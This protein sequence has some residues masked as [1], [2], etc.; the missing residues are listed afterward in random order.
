M[1]NETIKWLQW[2]LDEIINNSL[3]QS[4]SQEDT[5][6]NQKEFKEIEKCIEWV[7]KQKP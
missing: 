7:K 3:G 5:E 6:L 1:K 2:H 4:M